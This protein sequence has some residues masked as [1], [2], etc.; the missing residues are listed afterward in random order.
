MTLYLFHGDN[1]A[2]SRQD[3]QSLLTKHKAENRALSYLDGRSLTHKDLELALFTQNLFQE[4]TLI[5]EDLFSR[6]KSK[7]KDSCLVLIAN[8]QGDKDLVLWEKK[9]LTKTILK[10]FPHLIAKLHKTPVS[11][12]RFLDSLSPQNTKQSL[13]YLHQA[14]AELEEGFIFIMFVRRISDLLI[15]KSGDTSG[16]SPWLATRLSSQ[17]Q[18]WPESTLLSLHKQLAEFDYKYK[19]GQTK[20]TYLDLLDISISTLVR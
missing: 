3:M 2:A 20:L 14:A 10:K 17:A 13:D 9:E 1:L 15:A 16:L 6:P 5:I 8:Y 19:T 11:I 7:E 12:F 18:A 4:E